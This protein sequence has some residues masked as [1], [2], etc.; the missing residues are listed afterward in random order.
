MLSDPWSRPT[1][2]DLRRLEER[3]RNAPRAALASPGRFPCR[4]PAE[5]VSRRGNSVSAMTRD[6]GPA[7]ATLIHKGSI[8]LG[9]ARLRLASEQEELAYS[10]RVESCVP[11]SGG[12]FRSEISISTD[13]CP[14]LWR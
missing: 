1:L 6:M 8:P 14:T 12:L 10:A 5:L 13:E 2:E 3:Q 9:E 11:C 4:I 7:G